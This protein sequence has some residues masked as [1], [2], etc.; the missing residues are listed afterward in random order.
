MI[1]S[2]TINYNNSNPPRGY[3]WLTCDG[4]GNP[5]HLLPEKINFENGLN[6][7]IG[8]NGCG[9]TTLLKL[10]TDL[11]FV[12]G[13]STHIFWDI[14]EKVYPNCDWIYK[15]YNTIQDVVSISNNFDCPIFKID[16]LADKLSQNYNQIDNF[17]DFQQFWSERNMSK[18]QKTM[19]GLIWSVNSINEQMK[20]Y[21]WR[22]M[23]PKDYEKKVNDTWATA[24]D[25]LYKYI[26]THNNTTLEKRATILMDEP[27]EG[28]DIN[29][30]KVLKE[31]LLKARENT[32]VIA[33][34][35]NQLLIDSLSDNANVIEL[36]KDY[37]QQIR[38]F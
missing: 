14:V 31:F 35:H 13:L 34:L 30:L 38:E 36:S 21:S 10:I 3:W 15:D 8:N 27:D 2:V 20:N 22:N 6:I 9:K 24:Y 28:L 32:Q 25:M 12:R 7:V 11:C 5:R 23:F 1:E 4:D 16:S 19:S 37:L 17:K 29:N 26:D 18:G 33:V